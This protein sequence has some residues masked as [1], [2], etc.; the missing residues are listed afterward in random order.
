[1]PKPYWLQTLVGDYEVLRTCTQAGCTVDSGFP[2]T[3]TNDKKW[4]SLTIDTQVNNKRQRPWSPYAYRKAIGWGGYGRSRLIGSWWNRFT[5]PPTTQIHYVRGTYYFG[6]EY[7]IGLSVTRPDSHSEANAI[8]LAKLHASL[9][10]ART[11]WQLA[12][13]LGEARETAA[14]IASTARRLANGFFAFKKG[15]VVEAYRHLAGR[16]E[17]VP[18]RHQESFRKLRKKSKNENWKDDVSSAWMEF[19]YAWKPLLGD[20]D[21]AARYLAE[22]HVERRYGVYDINRAHK[23]VAYTQVNQGIGNDPR[24]LA[25]VKKQSKVRYIYEVYPDF[26]RKPST[27]NELG[28]TDPATVTWEL[29]PLSFV[30][31]WFVN[32]GQVLESLHEF[33]QWKVKRG[34]KSSR[35]DLTKEQVLTKNWTDG[36]LTSE[37]YPPQYSHHRWCDRALL[38]TLPTAVPLRIK[39]SN[40]FDLHLGQMASAAVLLR[41]AFR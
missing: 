30:V 1:M 22:K 39:V 32:V 41:Y 8:A 5:P 20:I 12:V 23:T 35:D 16:H 13:S 9:K 37:T 24:Y 2:R 21:S 3:V 28:F 18:V 6:C 17:A 14:H 15:K 29:L 38:G 26:L 10:E 11:Q 40:P 4:R 34:M 25:T 7:P 31:D 27:M 36:T 33:K 19:T